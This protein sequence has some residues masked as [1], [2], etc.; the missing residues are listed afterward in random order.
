MMNRRF[1]LSVAVVIS[2]F[3]HA[4]ANY[5]AEWDIDQLMQTLAQ[6]HS[7]HAIFSEQKTI[8]LL[9]KPLVSS[10]ELFY[11]APDH[12]EKRTLQPKAETLILNGDTVLIV[13]G[14]RH[15]QLKL[16]DY[17]VLAAFIDSIRGT[18]AGERKTLE[19]TYALN[20]K[21]S[22]EHWILQLSPTDSRIK[23]QIARIRIQG[24]NNELRRIEIYQTDGDSSIMT[25]A[26]PAMP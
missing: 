21:G 12:F 13:R 7:S 6:V 5:A 14:Q 22:R 15:Y 4:T 1:S 3:A 25:I 10:G 18:L 24:A 17:P 8:A 16:A 23:V 19:R 26:N 2:L 9:D 20:L 11:T